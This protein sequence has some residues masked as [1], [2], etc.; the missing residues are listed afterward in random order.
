[1]GPAT[2]IRLKY[3]VNAITKLAASALVSTLISTLIAAIFGNALSRTAFHL[4]FLAVAGAI[5]I[6]LRS[7]GYT[8]GRIDAGFLF[9]FFL[10]EAIGPI[11][12]HQQ[13]P[14]ANLVVTLVLGIAVASFFV[15]KGSNV[16]GKRESPATEPVVTDDG[17]ASSGAELAGVPVEDLDELVPGP[18]TRSR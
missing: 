12:L 5:G 4:L 18:G 1:M 10:F 6:I 16:V 9:A 3:A 17:G 7:T 11:L 15:N 13:T 14:P 8:I 2:D